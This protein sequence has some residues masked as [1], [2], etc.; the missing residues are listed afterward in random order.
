MDV[1]SDLTIKR[2]IFNPI[3]VQV[4]T[5]GNAAQISQKI[6]LTLTSSLIAGDFQDF[7]LTDCR[8]N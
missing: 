5:C 4:A 2:S 8:A 7:T 3:T 6:H 1:L